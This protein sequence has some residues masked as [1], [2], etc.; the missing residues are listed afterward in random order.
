[1]SQVLNALGKKFSFT[2]KNASTTTAIVIAIL[3]GFLDTQKCVAN[4]TT[5]AVTISYNNSAALV[6]AGFAVGA[7]A[8]DGTIA[9]DVTCTSNNAKYTVKMFKDYIQSQGLS[10]KKLIIQANNP[11]VF[12]N[13]IEITRYTPLTG[14][15]PENLDLNQFYDAYQNQTSKIEIDFEKSGMSLDLAFNTIMLMKLGAAREVTLTFVF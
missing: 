12:S 14:S 8:D 7:V 10:V 1:M 11:D 15:A 3:A 4:T 2:L 9:T 5:G 6:A 13:E